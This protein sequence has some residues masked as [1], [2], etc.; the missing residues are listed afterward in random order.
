LDWLALAQ[1]H[2]LPT[3]LLDWTEDPLK[4]LWFAL[5][6]S[7]ERP[8]VW[9]LPF[10]V[11]DVV[12]RERGR[13]MVRPARRKAGAPKP[14]DDPFEVGGT[15]KRTLLFKPEPQDISP[16]IESQDGWLALF[17][18]REEGTEGP[19]SCLEA[20]K[21]YKDLVCCFRIDLVMLSELQRKL[22]KD[23]ISQE[24]LFPDTDGLSHGLALRL[25][26]GEF[27]RGRGSDGNA[28]P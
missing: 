8:T 7:H 24:R 20:N 2:S 3:R 12:Y 4:A 19:Q 13:P 22:M 28:R 17:P 27:G 18:D 16:R 1:H 6:G 25:R 15:T 5:W 23:G 26:L 14:L 9:A 11:E 10:H 21:R